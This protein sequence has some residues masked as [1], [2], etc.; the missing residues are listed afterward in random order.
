MPNVSGGGQSK[1]PL[2]RMLVTVNKH[3]EESDEQFYE[4]FN[5]L[6][7]SIRTS[8]CARRAGSSTKSWTKLPGCVWQ[9]ERGAETGRLH[10]HAAFRVRGGKRM[11]I[12]A[13]VSSCRSGDRWSEGAPQ[14]E[15][16]AEKMRGTLEEAFR[17]VTKE[18]TRVRGPF[19]D[20]PPPS[21]ES[22]DL[23]PE[24]LPPLRP[25]QQCVVN[26][27]TCPDPDNP[28]QWR[29]RTVFWLWE[30]QGAVGKTVLLRHLVVNHRAVL[31]QGPKRHCKAVAYKCPADIY[32]FP[33]PRSTEDPD[34][35]C[36]EDIK[37]SIYMSHFSDCTGMV[38]RRSP[39]I[40]VLANRRCS[41]LDGLSRDRW[42]E[43][44]ISPAFRLL[45]EQGK[46]RIN[47]MGDNECINYIDA[48]NL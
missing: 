24:D 28:E 21:L 46:E 31:L 35:G 18:D 9:F 10:V 12:S 34:L 29:Q 19:G 22:Y 3:E 23:R 43:V 6:F 40:L 17:Y 36:I 47:L 20:V 11:R 27:L 37:D 39:Q 33:I 8:R 32:V 25:W 14:R 41:N 42:V 30:N 2:H 16:K 15:V 38:A 4:K 44:E 5:Q 7:Q 26:T 13:V 48:F 1:N 45:C